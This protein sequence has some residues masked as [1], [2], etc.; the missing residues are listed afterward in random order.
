[1]DFIRGARQSLW[2]NIG[3]KC[4]SKTLLELDCTDNLSLLGENV[5]KMD[6]FWVFLRVQ[7]AGIDLKINVK[8][9]LSS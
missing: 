2:E 4:E 5:S 6:N 8:K 9:R 3:F 7:G 1:M